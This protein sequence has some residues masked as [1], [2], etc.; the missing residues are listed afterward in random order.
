MTEG[1]AIE[2]A[3]HT[4]H[5]WGVGENY[6]MRY[7]HYT[8]GPLYFV[9][10]DAQNEV[11]ILLTP[12]DFTQVSSQIGMFQLVQ[13]GIQE[14]QYVHTGKIRVDNLADLNPIQVKFL[15]VI[16]INPKIK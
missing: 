12:D 9:D 6:L 3:R 16:P 13:V 4:M 15:Q 11:F 5:E 10:I 8:L 7:R 2:V 14:Q 1:I